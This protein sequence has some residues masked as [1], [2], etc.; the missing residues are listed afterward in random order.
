MPRS[1]E[2]LFFDVGSTL[3][4]E[5]CAY[6][7][8]LREIADAAQV[9]YKEVYALAL[10]FYKQN[11]K[12]DREAANRLGVPMPSWHKEHERLYEDT[13]ACLQEL[14][15]RYK[16]G[17]IANQSPGTETRLSQYGISEYIDLVVASAEAGVSKPN[18]RIF[19]LALSRAGCKPQNAIMIGDRIDNDIIPA[20]SMGMRTVWIRQGLWGKCWSIT[21]EEERADYMV[22][23]L[24][25]LCRLL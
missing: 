22:D 7:H 24:A 12:G 11:R 8:R 1:A 18:L 14:S 13:V 6:E 23:S 3:V 16:I 5:S 20:K 2:W 9:A 4:D 10:D 17:V 19:Q 25:E 21:K 15:G